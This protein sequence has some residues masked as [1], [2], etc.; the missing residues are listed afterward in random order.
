MRDGPEVED[1]ERRGVRVVP[2]V[3]A[4]RAFRPALAGR[5]VALEDELGVGR[6]PRVDPRGADQ[7]RGR[8]AQEAGERQLVDALGQR[9]DG[10]EQQAG[11]APTATATG[12]AWPRFSASW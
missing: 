4:E 6:H 10:G 2:E 1:R 8:A 11:S 9:R 5:H 12:S 7:R 3:V